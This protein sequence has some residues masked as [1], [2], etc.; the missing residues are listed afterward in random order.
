MSN[1]FTLIELLIATAVIGILAAVAIPS[2]Q[3]YI[4]SSRVSTAKANAL[5][6][7]PFLE[8]FY[9]ETGSYIKDSDT[10]YDQAELSS[11]F[12]WSA[13]LDNDWTYLVTA[14]SDT[15]SITLTKGD[16]SKTYTK[17]DLKL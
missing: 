16:W 14:S 2:Y 15:W 3:G 10:S 9:L 5:S 8:E 4:E 17:D 11:Y 1:G 6:I 7:K 13:D 12:G